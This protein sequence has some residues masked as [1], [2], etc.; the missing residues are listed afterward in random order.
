MS[1]DD[2]DYKK[3]F[4]AAEPGSFVPLIE[5][6]DHGISVL[7][8]PKLP[9]DIV[10]HINSMTKEEEERARDMVDTLIAHAWRS[11][12]VEI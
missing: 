2:L 1:Y 12:G 10:A 4:L 5:G 7:K 3:R 9:P 8:R 6:E 11:F